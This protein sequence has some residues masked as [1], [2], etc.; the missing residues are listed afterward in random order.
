MSGDEPRPYGR[1]VETFGLSGSHRRLLAEVTP[2]ARVL[3]VGCATGYLAQVLT[4]QGCS[5][6]GFEYD[7]QAAAEAAQHC[8][9]VVVG[10]IQAEAE[11]ARIPNGFDFVLLGDVLEH[12]V[13][14]WT[15]LAAMRDPLGPDGRVV[16][17]VP[18]VA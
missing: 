15:V 2:G 14:P 4:A 11:R 17:S 3:D 8:D 16:I 1:L 10:D 6:T 9:E 7:R 18:N 5:V 13:D 12:L